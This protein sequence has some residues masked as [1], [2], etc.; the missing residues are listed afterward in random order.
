VAVE[1]E[2]SPELVEL[3]A[4]EQ[5][6]LGQVATELTELLTQVAVAVEQS[7]EHPETEVLALLLSNTQTLAQL[8][9]ELA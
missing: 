5:V 3:V 7:L 6:Q 2:T 4:V 1:A 8:Q 9:S